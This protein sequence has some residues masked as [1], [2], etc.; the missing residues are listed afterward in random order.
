[1]LQLRQP[2]G[3]KNIKEK[4]SRGERMNEAGIDRLTLAI[5]FQKATVVTPVLKANNVSRNILLP[6]LS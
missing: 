6:V 1:M 3:E 5:P 4:R 2:K